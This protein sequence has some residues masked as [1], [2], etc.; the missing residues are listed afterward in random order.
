MGL[1]IDPTT[2]QKENIIAHSIRHTVFITD[3]FN[4]KFKVKG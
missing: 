3:F 4:I 2:I 1:T